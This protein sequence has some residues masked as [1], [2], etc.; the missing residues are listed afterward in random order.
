G[1]PVAAIRRSIAEVSAAA[2][3]GRAPRFSVSVR[4]ILGATEEKAWARARSILERIVEVR[5]GEATPARPQCV[6][7]QRLLDLAAHGEV[8][9]MRLWTAISAAI[10]AAG[11]SNALVV[12]SEQVASSLLAY[13]DAGA[14]TV[15]TRGIY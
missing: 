7:S 10:G 4:P 14:S 15:L 3:P 9:D 12:T 2:P 6:G 8:H 5:R 11:S 13:L 1:E